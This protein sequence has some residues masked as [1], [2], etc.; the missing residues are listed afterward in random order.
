M[1]EE[2]S[3]DGGKE[4]SWRRMR[5]CFLLCFVVFSFTCIYN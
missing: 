1:A 3:D 2:F 5:I 4:E